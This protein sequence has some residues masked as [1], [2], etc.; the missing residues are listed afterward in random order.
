MD[1]LGRLLRHLTSEDD[2]TAGEHADPVPRDVPTPEPNGPQ[3]PQPGPHSTP[4]TP[5]APLGAEP[6]SPVEGYVRGS[7]PTVDTPITRREID[8]LGHLGGLVRTPRAA[9]RL[10]N[11]YGLLRST[12]ALH[13]GSSFLGTDEEPGSYQAIAQLLGVLTAAPHLL[14]A[15]L[16]GR[17]TDDGTRPQ[18]LCGEPPPSWR[19][20]VASLRPVEGPQGWANSVAQGLTDGEVEEWEWLVDELTAVL[21]HVDLD[22]IGVYRAWAP[23]VARFSFVL[24]SF[25]AGR[26]DLTGGDV[27]GGGSA[28]RQPASTGTR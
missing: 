22:D 17:R 20:F 6:G 15:M 28:L 11:V 12:R 27:A 26:R 19:R 21:P 1:D 10:V 23:Q 5:P 9:T 16:W 3:P 7:A 18:G 2:T 8:L 4:Q 13:E 14:R 25:A 24:S